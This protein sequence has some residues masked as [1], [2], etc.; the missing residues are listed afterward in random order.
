MSYQTVMLSVLI[1]FCVFWSGF[2]LGCILSTCKEHT[3]NVEEGKSSPDLQKQIDI[4]RG[5]T[6]ELTRRAEYK[7]GNDGFSE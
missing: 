5:H 6:D 7:G 1:L 4:L 2:W 3:V